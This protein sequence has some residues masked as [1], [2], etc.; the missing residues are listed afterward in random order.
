[1]AHVKYQSVPVGEVRVPRS[2]R[3]PDPDKV[4][5]LA[6]S[7]AD[8]GMNSPIGLRPDRR[9]VWGGHR[10]AAAKLLKWDKIDAVIFEGDDQHAE[11]AEIDENIMRVELPALVFAQQMARRKEIY[12]ALHPVQKAGG[13]RKSGEEIISQGLGNDPAPRF[14]EA[15]SEML[16]ISES[17]V[18]AAVAVAGAIEPDVQTAIADLP[19]ADNA[20]DLKRLGD[21]TP[22]QQR[23]AA[24][25]LAAGKGKRLADVIDPQTEA[26]EAPLT[27]SD[28]L[29]VDVPPHL[30]ETF[31]GKRIADLV[32]RCR[33]LLNE[34]KAVAATKDGAW[35]LLEEACAGLGT[36]RSV[37][38][39]AKPYALCPKCEGAARGCGH[40]RKSGFVPQ[41]RHEEMAAQEA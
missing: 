40:C 12:E 17:S 24:K 31:R 22:A 37:L 8:N 21:L 36:A 32:K 34:V 41:W 29:G 16:G 19:I 30:R 33:K 6:S 4:A 20:A 35:L 39:N 26:E 13:D 9:L 5:A 11:L 7:F 2:R 15:T 38:V 18:Q 25:R 27:V 3:K 14:T 28:E 1:M 23:K 10:L